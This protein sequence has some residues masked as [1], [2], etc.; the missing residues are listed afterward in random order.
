[1]YGAN[2]VQM[3]TVTRIYGGAVG[4]NDSLGIV[5]IGGGSTVMQVTGGGQFKSGVTLNS[6]GWLIFNG[7]ADIGGGSTVTGNLDVGGSLTTGVNFHLLKSGGLG[8]T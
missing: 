4:S 8:G 2:G 6:T 1:M 5:D 3:S 7:S